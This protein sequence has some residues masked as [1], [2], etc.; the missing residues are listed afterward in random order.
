MVGPCGERKRKGGEKKKVMNERVRGLCIPPSV[1]SATH[2]FGDSKPGVHDVESLVVQT[3][4]NLLSNRELSSRRH[5]VA[6]IK[7]IQP[8][9]E[10]GDVVGH[11]V[12]HDDRDGDVEACSLQSSLV[13][14]CRHHEV[15]GPGSRVI[16]KM[17]GGNKRA[18]GDIGQ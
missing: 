12:G 18:E 5:L 16:C 6:N 11:A 17:C 7:V 1:L 9:A 14:A 3:V 2:I 10:L 15:K 13:L 8:L 4:S